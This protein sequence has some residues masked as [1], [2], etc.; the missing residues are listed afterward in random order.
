MTLIDALQSIPDHRRGAGQRY[1]LW[2]FLL[3]IIL[4]TMSGYRGYR[5]LARFM[6]RHQEHLSVRLGLPRAQLPSYSTI[7]RLLL[8][9]DFNAV[10]VAFNQWA[11]QAG[12]MKAGDNCAIDGKGLKNTVTDP[13]EAQQ[14]FVN[15][16]SVF[17]LEQGLVVGQLCFE[18]KTQSEIQAVYT[19]LEQLQLSGVTVSL[20]AL[21][22]Q[23]K[24]VELLNKTGNDYVIAVKKNQKGLYE[25][26]QE[27]SQTEAVTSVHLHEERTR[28]RR[29]NRIVSV[30]PLAADIKA[31]WQGAQQGVEVV[32]YGT[33][34]GEPYQECSYYITSWTEQADRLQERIR[35]HWGIENPLHWVKDV[36]LGEDQSS[37][38]AKSSATLMAV[39]RNLVITVFRRA[40]HA[41]ITNAIDRFSNNLNQLLPMLD[42]SSG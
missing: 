32:R 40:G 39:I 28:S 38:A 34:N 23:K 42:F 31:I 24:T 4:G 26:L 27:L 35:A 36:V 20:D 16:V 14:N 2:V 22:A 29:T 9:I 10:A 5:G 1:P 37:I 7:R 19:L 30:F 6:Q 25:R 15:V 21:H 8:E 18:N 12:L 33:R 13:F 11:Q 3:L 17:Q 41:S